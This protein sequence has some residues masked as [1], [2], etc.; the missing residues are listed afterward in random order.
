MPESGACSV[1]LPPNACN[2]ECISQWEQRDTIL[3][4]A[5]YLAL[6]LERHIFNLKDKNISC[7]LNPQNVIYQVNG[8]LLDCKVRCV[9]E[10][11]KTLIQFFIRL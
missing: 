9:R 1:A 6:L 11:S 3:Y 2:W 7:R 8:I 5:K 10:K 4:G